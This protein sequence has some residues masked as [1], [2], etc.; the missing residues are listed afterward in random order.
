MLIGAETLSKILDKDDRSTAILFGDGAGAVILEASEENCFLAVRT[1]CRRQPPRAALR[2]RQR[3]RA[4][5][6]DHA[7]T[8]REAASDPHVGPR[9]VQARPSPR[10]SSRR[11]RCSPRRNLTK[12]DVTFLVPHQANKRIIDATARY[13][14]LPGRQSHREHRRVRKHVGR[15]DSDGALGN[16]ARRARSSRRSRSSSWPSAAVSRGEPSRGGGR[17]SAHRR[18]LS[19]PRF[20]VRRHGLRRRRHVPPRRA[21]LFDRAG[22]RA[23]L[24]SAGAAS[25]TVPKRRCARRS[26]VSRPSSRRTSRSMPR[27]ATASPRSSRRVTRLPSSAAWSSRARWRSKRRCAS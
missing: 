2:A 8:R 20:A 18:R 3:V 12:A 7:A 10:W 22:E 13:L 1:R 23:R 6:I 5:P 15:V 21:T 25:R 4:K 14:E 19:G 26:T 16:R 17:H 11:T 24:R 27:S 9:D